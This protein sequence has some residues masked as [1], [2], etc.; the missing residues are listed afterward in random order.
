MLAKLGG[1]LGMQDLPGH[2]APKPPRRYRLDQLPQD[3]SALGV[4]PVVLVQDWFSALFDGAAQRDAIA[5]LEA[6]GYRPW[7]LKLH[8]AGKVAQTF[9]ALPAFKAMAAR[10]CAALSALER[11]GVPLVGLDPA[12][13]MQLR[14]DY[15][16]AGFTPPPV[17]LPQEFL[18]RELEAGR[19][20]P[21]AHAGGTMRLF[22][23]CTEST[24]LPAAGA[25]W[26]RVYAALGLAVETPSTGCCGM[27]GLFGHQERHQDVSRRLFDLSWRGK[28]EG[29]AQMAA[30]GFSC[31]CQA[32]RLAGKS[33]RHPLGLIAQALTEKTP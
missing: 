20:F 1:L 9:G 15:P 24:A 10:L 28:L 5:G 23:H 4:R 22:S 16:K 2:F 18:V 13:V 8:P 33:L 19:V 30:S 12:L 7:L 21:Q 32:A 14:Q 6:L 17:A 31:R 11:L 3:V 25:L 26:Q 27:A 29:G